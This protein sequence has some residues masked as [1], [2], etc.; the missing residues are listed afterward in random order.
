MNTPYTS[1][2]ISVFVVQYIAILL[3]I[4]YTYGLQSL[5]PIGNIIF[6]IT[7]FA[8][9]LKIYTFVAEEEIIHID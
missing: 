8:E 6:T 4:S 9:W 1:Y 2:T 3:W 5:I 7:V